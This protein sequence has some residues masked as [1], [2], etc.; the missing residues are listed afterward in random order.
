MIRHLLKLVWH[1]KRANALLTIEIFASFLIVF[2][3]ATIGIAL[4]AR[5]NTPLGFDWH[6][7]WVMSVESSVNRSVSGM[8]MTPGVGP[9]RSH[10]K[11][12]TEDVAALLQELKGFPEVEVAAASSMPPYSH[13]TWGTVM[14]VHGRRVDVTADNVSDDFARAMNV[15]VLQGRWFTD[16]D[17]AQN[18]QPVVVDSDLAKALFGTANAVGQ[19]IPAHEFNDDPAMPKDFKIVGVTAPFRQSGEFTPSKPNFAFFRVS[20][21]FP[22]EP[23]ASQIIIRVK[24]GTPRSFDAE[25]YDRFRP[26]AGVRYRIRRMEDMRSE[27]TRME[28]TPLTALAVIA[29]FLI[30][31][32]ALGLTGVLWQTVTRRT[33]EI[34]LRRAVGAS[35]SGVRAQVLGEVAVLV[36]FAVIAGTLVVVQLPLLGVF[37]VFTPADFT[38]GLIAALAAIYGITLLCGAYPSWLAST[39]QPAEALHYD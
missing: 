9:D 13:R 11:Q 19:T 37:R 33:R 16:D 4:R 6:D 7:V 39:I 14:E 38:G 20:R 31:M 8:H 5:W 32:V 10:A 36:T 21:R 22:P 30:T 28:L 23:E 27:T 35:G 18:Y 15:H 34:G 29:L 2:V 24:P 1:R 12:S 25:L 3:V 26:P 17:E